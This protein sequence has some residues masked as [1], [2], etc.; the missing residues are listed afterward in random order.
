MSSRNLKKMLLNYLW[1]I[2]FIAGGI[3]A[4]ISWVVFPHEREKATLIQYL[5]QIFVFIILLAGISL[6]P[7]KNKFLYLF[8]IIPILAFNLY[9]APKLTFFAENKLY[10]NFYAL[11][12]IVLYPMILG[13]I[14][15]AYRLGGGK[16]GNTLKI[17][18]IGV[19]V[20]FSG[21]MDFMWFILNG[22]DYTIHA[23]SIPHVEAFI[24]HVPK[25]A[26]IIIF[27]SIHFLIAVGLLLL[28]IDK[29]FKTQSVP[30]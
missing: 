26:E 28:P 22:L 27:I 17:G 5:I 9:L 4:L 2:C 19:L 8:L 6:F 1:L 15:L 30:D 21:I 14:C 3:G 13:S 23:T 7:N 24:G 11:F 16:P 12:F 25:L 29:F 20:L 10:H 18:I